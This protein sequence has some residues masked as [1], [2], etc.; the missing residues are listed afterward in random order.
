MTQRAKPN[1][2]RFAFWST[3][4]C[5]VGRTY[6]C[7]DDTL[8]DSDDGRY[9]YSSTQGQSFGVKLNS[10]ITDPKTYYGHTVRI[11]AARLLL[12]GVGT[13]G[14]TPGVYVNTTLIESLGEQTITGGYTTYEWTMGEVAAALLSGNYPSVELWIGLTN[15]SISS[16]APQCRIEACDLT[17]PEVGAMNAGDVTGQATVANATLLGAAELNPV[18]TTV[19]GQAT[20]ATADL[21]G[22]GELN[23]V[24]TT[25]QGQATTAG[26]IGANGALVLDPT[27]VQGQATVANATL[28]G[29]GA[30]TGNSPG[31]ATVANASLLGAGALTGSANGLA[32]VYGNWAPPDNPKKVL[33]AAG[34]FET[35]PLWTRI[36]VPQGMLVHLKIENHTDV[37]IEG[38]FT[39]PDEAEFFLEAGVTRKWELVDSPVEGGVYARGQ[40]SAPTTGDVIAEAMFK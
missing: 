8:I 36:M 7:V 17:A 13:F 10:G 12:G 16:G 34:S 11:R 24:P 28:L 2:T 1:A 38:S 21:S 19:Q 22:A 31:Q 18:P 14:L 37:R 26:T 9:L 39:T 5:A 29:G 6:Q 27:P 40:A 30:L 15:A 35:F 3:S 23:P 33:T 20:V 25:V 4:G 32:H